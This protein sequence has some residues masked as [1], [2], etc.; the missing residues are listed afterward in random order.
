MVLLLLEGL[1]ILGSQFAIVHL[2]HVALF[3]I[4]CPFLLLQVAGLMAAKFAAFDALA[5]ARLLVVF[6]VLDGQRLLWSFGCSRALG[7]SCRCEQRCDGE[8]SHSVSHGIRYRP[9]LLGHSRVF[10]L[11][12]VQ[13]R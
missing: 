12:R 2:A 6:T 3:L 10:S 1:A 5:N 9:L 7:E 4:K 8:C 11:H 13:T